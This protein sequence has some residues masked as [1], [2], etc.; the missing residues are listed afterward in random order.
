MLGII[1]TYGLE[2][3][4]RA[5]TRVKRTIWHRTWQ[6]KYVESYARN[7]SVVDMGRSGHSLVMGE[8]YIPVDSLRVRLRTPKG[9]EL[10]RIEESPHYQLIHSIVESSERPESSIAYRDYI[11]TFEP[12]MNPD[13]RIV[14]LRELVCSIKESLA[15]EKSKVFVVVSAPAFS[16]HLNI[17]FPIQD[18]VHRASIARSL[19]MSK[20]RVLLTSEE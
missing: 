1:L 11:R 17:L 13:D 2:L 18:G 15:L 4:V 12:D 5:L 14:E 7:T 19:G 6:R 10:C 9:M 20:I 3:T 16:L 8:G